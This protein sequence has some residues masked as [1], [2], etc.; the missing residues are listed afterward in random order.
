MRIRTLLADGKLT[1]DGETDVD[2]R[3]VLRLRGERSGHLGN[4]AREPVITVGVE[5]LVDAKT[6]EPVQVSY[7]ISPASVAAGT[8]LVRK[9]FV[10]FETL[11]L[12][13]NEALL[14]IPDA[15][16]RRVVRHR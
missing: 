1:P 7:R 14:R 8:A 4:I 12:A 6:Y 9:T 11:P 15:D 16:Q 5:Y 2:G 13:G 10:T 3:H